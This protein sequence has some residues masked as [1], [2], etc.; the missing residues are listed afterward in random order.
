[1]YYNLSTTV[2][3]T[4]DRHWVICVVCLQKDPVVLP[5]AAILIPELSSFVLKLL[6]YADKQT[7]A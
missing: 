1:M 5:K 2:N 7:S 6:L 3:Y 4:L